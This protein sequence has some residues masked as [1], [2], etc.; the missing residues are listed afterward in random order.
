M[1]KIT[2]FFMALVVSLGMVGSVYAT[3]WKI[4]GYIPQNVAANKA[5]KTV[6]INGSFS[7][8]RKGHKV[9]IGTGGKVLYDL[10]SQIIVWTLGQVKVVLPKS[11]P[12]GKYW[13]AIY[14]SGDQLLVKG[15]ETFEVI[16]KIRL[17]LPKPRCP[18]GWKLKPGSVD[19]KKGSFECVPVK[20]KLN[21]PDG[22]TYFETDCSIGC[23]PVPW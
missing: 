14:T 10:S 9:K 2:V 21:C 22:T 6:T 18:Q 17:V 1:K 7:G 15:D 11:I 20:P 8:Y 23:Q 4:T 5:Y 19:Y 16:K 3:D 13:L 12:P